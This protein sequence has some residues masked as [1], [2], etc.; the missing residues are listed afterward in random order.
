MKTSFQLP[1]LLNGVLICRKLACFGLCGALL[2]GAAPEVAAEEVGVALGQK[3]SGLAQ[4]RPLPGGD[5]A[6]QDKPLPMNRGRQNNSSKDRGQTASPPKS[7][8]RPNPRQEQPKPRQE[9]PKPRQEQPKPRQEQPKTQQIQSRP[10]QQINQSRTETGQTQVRPLPLQTN[11]R[12]TTGRDRG[13]EQNRSGVQTNQQSR[14]RGNSAVPVVNQMQSRPPQTQTKSQQTLG[15]PP[16]QINQPRMQTRQPQTRPLPLQ[17]NIRTGPG[18]DRGQVYAPPGLVRS[19]SRERGTFSPRSTLGVLPF[20]KERKFASPRDQDPGRPQHEADNNRP[21]HDRYERARDRD[22]DRRGGR[23][24]HH[25][26][27]FWCYDHRHLYSGDVYVYNSYYTGPYSFG[28]D[29]YAADYG[30]DY[31]YDYGYS[32]SSGYS[33]SSGDSAV[34]YEAAYSPEDVGWEAYEDAMWELC[35]VLNARYPNFTATPTFMWLS[36]RPVTVLNLPGSRNMLFDDGIFR[37]GDVLWRD[38]SIA[39]SLAHPQT[40][41][42]PWGAGGRNPEP[43]FNPGLAQNR[44][45]LRELYGATPE[46]VRKSCAEVSFLG[47]KVLFNQRQGAAEALKR[48]EKRLLTHLAA[49]PADRRYFNAPL[50]ETLAASPAAAF[51][52]GLW[53][54]ISQ[55]PL[56]ENNPTAAVVER[57]RRDF[58]Q[59]IVDAFEAEGFI[60]GGK[61]HD[62][63][64]GYFEYQGRR[65]D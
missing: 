34:V 64:F 50:G 5:L 57:F 52:V 36:G 43:G 28:Y 27:R 18:R 56:R 41:P 58:P 40:A 3:E 19:G 37:E 7:Q 44:A 63:E 47:R 39:D 17:T 14:D 61:W 6:R 15:R 21:H 12:T 42:Y 4:L 29:Y 48:V 65:I 26:S 32:Y 59:G 33:S 20:L 2:L 11:T 51:G 8:S 49:H 23:H 25:N 46:L 62:Y 22:H 55:V 45:L 9:Q 53:L 16:Q 60:W 10:P 54:D 13:R 31:A 30:S 38:A 24:H 1:V 35:A